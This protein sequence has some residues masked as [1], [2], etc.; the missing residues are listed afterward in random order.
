[1]PSVATGT[2]AE[3]IPMPTPPPEDEALLE[4]DARDTRAHAWKG[5][6]DEGDV[7]PEFQYQA[8]KT[9]GEDEMDMTPMVDVTFLLLIFFMVTASFVTQRSIEQPKPSEDQ[10]STNVQDW[11]D[12][13]DYVEVIIDQNNVYR[14]TSRDEEEVEAPSDPEMRGQMRNAYERL[15]A[16][17]LVITAHEECWHEKVVKVWDYGTTLGFEEIEVKTTTQDY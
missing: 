9:E 12:Q 8:K 11:E 17:K 4:V 2:P 16:R 1:M 10:P 13:N 14:V 15:N 5:F 7:P 3:A 6:E